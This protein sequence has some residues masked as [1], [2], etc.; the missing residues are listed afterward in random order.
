MRKSTFSL[1][2]MPF[3]ALLGWEASATPPG[4]P[5]GP[6]DGAPI[7]FVLQICPEGDINDVDVGE[8]EATVAAGLPDHQLYLLELPPHINEQAVLQ[9]IAVNQNVQW[10]ELNVSL[11]VTDGS[12]QSFFFNV[13]KSAYFDQYAFSM[14]D[15]NEPENISGGEG[16]IVALLDTGIDATHELLIGR[17]LETGY[18]FIDWN[19]DTSESPDSAGA[20]GGHGTFM[21]GL[22][23]YLAPQSQML[24]VRVLNDDG[25]GDAF[26]AAA[27]ILHA[28]DNGAHVINMSFATAVDAQVIRYAVEEAKDAGILVVA[29]SGNLNQVEPL[30]PAGDLNAFAVAATDSLDVKSPF[31]NYGG[32]IN[33]SA[34]GSAIVSTMPGDAYAMADG[35]SMAAAFV[36]AAAA[37]LVAD[38]QVNSL[39]MVRKRLSESALNIDPV[40][41]EHAGL[42]GSGRLRIHEAL[43]WAI[44]DINS[45][46]VVDVSDL[47]LL[48]GAWGDCG[49]ADNCPADLDANVQVD[50]SDL[51]LLLQS[52]SVSN[53]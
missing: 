4:D 25:T 23:A 45:D 50:I 2:S 8:Y 10:V 11:G 48:L 46:G 6:P 17:V 20:L 42:L 13:P 44:G 27:G 47:L 52:W 37:R 39:Q 16:V 28:I 21:A 43:N 15:D 32:H 49:D 26:H 51:L 9:M 40:N 5:L 3:I 34:P 38:E 12:T 29:A 53:V 22:V 35:T 24:P 7:Q 41:P 30:Y 14:L 36:S 33:I 1:V 31:S 18:N 19:T